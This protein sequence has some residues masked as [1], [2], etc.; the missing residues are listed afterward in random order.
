MTGEEPAPLPRP[1]PRLDPV[2]A[3]GAKIVLV[4]PP[5]AGKSTIGR[6]L[7]LRLGIPLV[8]T[9]AAI[10]QKHGP[11]DEIFAER[12][13]ARFREYEREQ[14]RRA[15][16][17]LLS[18]PGVVSLGGGAVLNPGTRAQLRHPAIKVVNIVID[19][20]TAAARLGGSKRPLLAGDED[21]VERWKAL[22]ADRAD[23]Y[24]SVATVT[25]TASSA[26]PTTVV[27]RIVDVLT[28]LQRAEEYAKYSEEPSDDPT[29][30][31]RQHG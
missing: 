30:R 4:G 9:D 18:E 23:L 22:V 20:D 29:A 12:G 27:N 6:M 28:G 17:R 31:R 2:P 26:P 1:A 13:E 11:I 19:A 14:V 24:D 8:D 3:A 10:V 16:R 21:P 7:A 15:L 25:V 5:A